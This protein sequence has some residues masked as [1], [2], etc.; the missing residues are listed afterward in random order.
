[1]LLY[2]PVIWCVFKKVLP[3]ILNFLIKKICL[4]TCSNLKTGFDSWIIPSHEAD[5]RNPCFALLKSL[6]NRL[7]LKERLIGSLVGKKTASLSGCELL[8]HSKVW[9]RLHRAEHKCYIYTHTYTYMLS[10]SICIEFLSY[11]LF[12]FLE[13]FR[14]LVKGT[15]IIPEFHSRSLKLESLILEPKALRAKKAEKWVILG[16]GGESKREKTGLPNF[17]LHFNFL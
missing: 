14:G 13:S 2:Q 17:I 9:A 10:H 15:G 16:G 11:S 7:L 5:L 6:A 1:M 8:S 4:T 12:N 3:H